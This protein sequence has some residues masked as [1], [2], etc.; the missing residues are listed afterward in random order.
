MSGGVKGG[1]DDPALLL[2]RIGLASEL[3]LR[4]DWFTGLAVVT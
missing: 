3:V 2:D 4:P 1:P